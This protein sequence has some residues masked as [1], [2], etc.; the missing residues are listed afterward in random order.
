MSQEFQDLQAA[1][2]A[3]RAEHAM[4]R[5]LLTATQAA[6]NTA[7]TNHGREMQAHYATQQALERSMRL[8][9]ASVHATTRRMEQVD[10]LEERLHASRTALIHVSKAR[11]DAQ[12]AHSK[13]K[14]LLDDSQA[15]LLTAVV[16]WQHGKEMSAHFQTKL[17]LEQ[18]QTLHFVAVLEVDQLQAKLK[19]T[20]ATLTAA[21]E[22]R[23]DAQAF[24]VN[25]F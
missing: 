23:D 25:R 14:A 10:E 3:E 12:D 6:L 11:D 19:A 13:T 9:R 21:C 7:I 24:A 15:S 5:T 22:A 1:L 18:A 4:T 2:E 17:E 16:H 8:H 20:D